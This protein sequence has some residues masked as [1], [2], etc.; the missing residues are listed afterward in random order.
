[1]SFNLEDNMN[2]STKIS[3]ALAVAA[4]SAAVMGFSTNANAASLSDTCSGTTLSSVRNCCNTWVRQHGKPMWM[5]DNRGSCSSAAAC[6]G[7]RGGGEIKAIAKIVTHRRC[8]I[9][10]VV[11][12]DKSSPNHPPPQRGRVAN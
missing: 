11:L 8:Y 1:M 5:M 7:G 4:L 2:I 6:S 9:D 12:I 3:A 10:Q